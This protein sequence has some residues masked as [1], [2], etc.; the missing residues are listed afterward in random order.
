MEK[1]SGIYHDIA[2][3][4]NGDVYIGVV[5]PVRC[6]KSTFIQKF[7]QNF[8]LDK[9]TNNHDK[10]RATDELPQASE[11]VM[12]MT[13]KP[14]FVPNEAVKI[15]I[16]STSMSMRLIDS[17]GFMVDGAVGA[18]DGDEPRLVKTPW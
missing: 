10:A 15:K 13:T 9:I 12:V 7:M 18:M 6:G 2:E 17:V 4:T 1:N 3:R 16:G 8:V 5:G 14:Q 11:G